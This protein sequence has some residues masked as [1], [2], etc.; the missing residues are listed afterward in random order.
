MNRDQAE[1][2]LTAARVPHA[3]ALVTTADEVIFESAVGIE[4]NSPHAI[5]SMTKPITSVAIMRM[6]EA[7]KLSLDTAVEDILPEYKD[8]AVIS[9]VDRD[10]GSYET[11]PVTNKLTIRHLLNHTAGFGYA[12]CNHDLMALTPESHSSTFPLLH[13]PGE[14]WTYGIATG[15]LGDVLCEILDQDLGPI[16]TEMVFEPLG[17]TNTSY[18]VRDDQADV[19]HQSDDGW[20]AM[21]AFPRMELGDAGLVSTADDYGK[22]LRCL[23]NKGAPLIDES[24]FEAMVSNQIGDMTI[25]TLPDADPGMT[26]P[27]PRGGGVDK[28]GLGFQIH[29][30]S[31]PGMRSAG[32]F[33]WCGLL[34]TYFWC[35]PVEQ[36]GAVLMMQTLPLYDEACLDLL[37]EFERAVY[38]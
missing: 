25:E 11:T 1:Q 36:I 34:N 13:Q 17:M 18:E 32:S 24:T 31:K 8:Q 38:A 3:V 30:E 15:V 14:R 12:F 19:H 2:A 37:D 27:F 22:F 7:G 10:A 26:R 5:M 9:Q 33:S 29:V 4:M 21:S 35:D 28:F 20:R 6:I 16:L 23:L